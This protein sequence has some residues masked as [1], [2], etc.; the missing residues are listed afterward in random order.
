MCF[1]K[2]NLDKFLDKNFDTLMEDHMK[3]FKGDMISHPKDLDSERIL[4]F[5]IYK[6]Y[7]SQKSLNLITYALVGL[8]TVLVALTVI[9]AYL[10][11]RLH[12]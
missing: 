11:Y 2:N 3:W 10:T 4:P 9:L 1:R 7:K 6:T 8:T 12:P 5:I